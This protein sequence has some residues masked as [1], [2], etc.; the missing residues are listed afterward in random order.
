VLNERSVKTFR[1]LLEQETNI[2]L[3]GFMVSP[4]EFV[5]HFK[6]FAAA[7]I[8]AIAYGQRI[9]SVDDRLVRLAAHPTSLAVAEGM[10]GPILVEAFPVLTSSD[11]GAILWDRG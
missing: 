9:T 11:M 4:D 2:L 3:E 7:T 6:R 1:P 8:L 10:V 5:K